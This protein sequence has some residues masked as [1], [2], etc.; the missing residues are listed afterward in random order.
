[1]GYSV[2]CMYYIHMYVCIYTHVYK[3]PYDY[4]KYLLPFIFFAKKIQL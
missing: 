3:K 4:Y 2:Y 1:M